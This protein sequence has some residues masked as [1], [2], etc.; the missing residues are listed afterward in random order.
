MD[1]DTRTRG[2]GPQTPTPRLVEA[3]ETAQTFAK[4]GIYA[5]QRIGELL[6]E[7]PKA[8]AGRKPND[9]IAVEE[10]PTKADALKDAGIPAPTAYQLEQ[11][12]ANPEIVE[13]V[14]AKAEADGRR[15]EKKWSKGER[16]GEM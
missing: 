13:A 5:D 10:L 16:G 12:A 15:G 3:T 7:L 11:L 1:S 14:I 9:S 2:N 6:R 8:T 4:V